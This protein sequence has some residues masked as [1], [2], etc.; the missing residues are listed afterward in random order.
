MTPE[1]EMTIYCPKGPH[2]LKG[3]SSAFC[4][5]VINPF[6][7]NDVSSRDME[8]KMTNKNSELYFE[9]LLIK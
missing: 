5:T 4:Q 7:L 1:K 9:L 6:R 3:F 8:G 2:V